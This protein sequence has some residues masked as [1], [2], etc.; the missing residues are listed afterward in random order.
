MARHRVDHLTDTQERILR[1]IR[2]TIAD[3]GASPT[4]E[5]IGAQVGLGSRSAVAYQLGEMERKGAIT[6]EPHRARGIRL[7]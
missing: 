3:K 5:E 2:Q 4:F 1:C 7:A 6:R